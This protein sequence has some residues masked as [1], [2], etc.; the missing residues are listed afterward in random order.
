MGYLLEDGTVVTYLFF[1]ILQMRKLETREASI[2]HNVE[3]LVHNEII[4][5]PWFQLIFKNWLKLLFKLF[6][7]SCFFERCTCCL[8]FL[9][10]VH[11]STI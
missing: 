4:F 9:F 10:S 8:Y 5:E 7:S 1:Y 6:A 3:Q 2:F 11:L